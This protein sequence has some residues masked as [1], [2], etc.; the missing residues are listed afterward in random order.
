MAQDFYRAFGVGTSETSLGTVDV[1]GVALAA[2]QGLYQ[3]S[4]EQAAEITALAAENADL[5]QQVTEMEARLS[6][7]EAAAGEGETAVGV[8]L[9]LLPWAGFAFLAMGV[10]W[11]T[12]RPEGVSI[13]RGGGR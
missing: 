8:D 7:L 10:V 1:D 3:R 13:R 9:S 11:V 12:R 5:Q 6:A 4:Q 2:V